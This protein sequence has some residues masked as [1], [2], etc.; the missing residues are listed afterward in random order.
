M[1]MSVEDYDRAVGL[2][3]R[4]GGAIVLIARIMP[5]VHGVVSI[6]AGVTRMRLFPFIVYTAIG[7]ALWIAPLTYFGLWLGNNWERVLYWMDVY[8]YGWYVVMALGVVVLVFRR[9]QARQARH[10]KHGVD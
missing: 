5:L 9:L 2:F 10:E 3:Q 8:E 7:S 1:I 6:P 4:W